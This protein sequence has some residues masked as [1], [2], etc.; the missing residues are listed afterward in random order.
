MGSK[1]LTRVN[2]LLRREIAEALYRI[3]PGEN[4][5][6]ATV[7]ITHVITSPNLRHARVLVSV[8]AEEEGQREVLRSLYRRRKEIQDAINR[9]MSLK[10]TPRLNFQLDNSLAEGD[11]V[12]DLLHGLE[13]EHPEWETDHDAAQDEPREPA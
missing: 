10:Y 13:T 1:R 5:D 3:L 6:L 8:R 7:T 11:H 4:V 2:E 12:L 9:D